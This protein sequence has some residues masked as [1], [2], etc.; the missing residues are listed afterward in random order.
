MTQT[1][2]NI[3]IQAENWP[4]KQHFTIA[5][6][7]KTNAHVVVV[8]IMQDGYKGRGEAV[9]YA[10]YGENMEIVTA[11]IE[12]I[13]PSLEKGLERARLQAAL[14]PGAARN[15]IDCALW[16]LQAKMEGQ[17]VW[18]LADLP[19]P[20]PLTTALTITIDQPAAMAQ[21][22]KRAADWPL[23]KIKL[24]GADNMAADLGRLAA[25]RQAVPH[26]ALI[27]DVNEGWQADELAMHVDTLKQFNL[28]LI[29]QPLPVGKDDILKQIDLPFCADESVHDR[30][31][32]AVLKGK[33]QW[34]NIKLDKTGGLTE[35]LQLARTAREQGFQ[36]MTGCMVATSLSLAPAYLVAQLCDICD[37]DGAFFLASDRPHALTYQNAQLTP[38][39]SQL[40]G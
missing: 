32:L 27:I 19:P 2:R 8:E 38:P 40:W 6:G 17:A 11:A 31:S 34:V 16:D 22:A 14:L 24:G 10:R 30:T 4:L 26:T 39:S 36:L 5:R 20:R 37:L 15:A 29:E 35:A 23:L 25:I 21:A 3:S 33:Y 1:A 7:T 9:P 12:Q 13:V 28:T 18:Q